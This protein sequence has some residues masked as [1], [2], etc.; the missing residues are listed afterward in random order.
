MNHGGQ[1]LEYT[2]HSRTVALHLIPIPLH[3]PLEISLSVH[4]DVFASNIAM[5]AVKHIS[6]PTTGRLE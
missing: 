1:V 5:V 2:V 3:Y 4:I 6:T